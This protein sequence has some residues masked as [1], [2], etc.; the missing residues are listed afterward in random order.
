M[1]LSHNIDMFIK[2]FLVSFLHITHG[3][4]LMAL[5]LLLFIL[6]YFIFYFLFFYFM[7][8]LN[9]LFN[10]LKKKKVHPKYTYTQ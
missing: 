7:E 1:I 8:R 4:I 2:Q 3:T 9:F 6:F 5:L 10:Q